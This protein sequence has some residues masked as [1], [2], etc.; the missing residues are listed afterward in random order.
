MKSTSAD[1]E[2]EVLAVPGEVTV[3]LLITQTES[4]ASI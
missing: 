1:A 3:A 2:E 4:E